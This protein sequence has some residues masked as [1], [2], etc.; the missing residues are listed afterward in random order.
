VIA[1]DG[2][3][4]SRSRAAAGAARTVARAFLGRQS[5]PC[6]L[7]WAR[8]PASLAVPF[9]NKEK[10]PRIP[11]CGGRDARRPLDTHTYWVVAASLCLVG[12]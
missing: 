4:G 2:S 9:S 12:T 8:R 3:S 6:R 10:P 1:P 7:T 5:E 11:G